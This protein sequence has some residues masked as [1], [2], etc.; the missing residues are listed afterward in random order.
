MLNVW[1]APDG[2]DGVFVV[3]PHFVFVVD[4]FELLRR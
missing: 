1:H 3:F 4:L 2:H